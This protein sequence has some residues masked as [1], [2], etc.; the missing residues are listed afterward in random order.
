MIQVISESPETL[1]SDS[2]I[3][4]SG[5]KWFSLSDS[6]SPETLISDSGIS[7]SVQLLIIQ[8]CLWRNCEGA[9]KIRRSE[10]AWRF[11]MGLAPLPSAPLSLVAKFPGAVIS[12]HRLIV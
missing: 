8:L 5:D 4:D 6:A 3:S 11:L 12:G 10:I 7:D 1:I 2:G 9:E